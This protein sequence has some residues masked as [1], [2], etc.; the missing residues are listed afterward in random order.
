MER[1]DREGED[2]TATIRSKKNVSIKSSMKKLKCTK[3]SYKPEY[4]NGIKV[5]Y[6]NADQ[7]TNKIELLR[8]R[9]K[10]EEPNE[11]QQISS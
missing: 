5:L 8:S 10:H 2:P 1:T 7:L 4:V 3:R 6:T 11:K 9:C